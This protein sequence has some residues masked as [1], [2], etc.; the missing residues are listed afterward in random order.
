MYAILVPYRLYPPSSPIASGAREKPRIQQEVTPESMAARGGAVRIEIAF[1]TPVNPCEACD[2]RTGRLVVQETMP[3]ALEDGMSLNDWNQ[4]R[5]AMQRLLD[6][7]A[8]L[9]RHQL[10]GSFVLMAFFILIFF[11]AAAS[12]GMIWSGRFIVIWLLLPSAM[13]GMFASN[14]YFERQIAD[15]VHKMRVLCNETSQRHPG[16]IFLVRTGMFGNFH[17]V[18]ASR[19]GQRIAFHIQAQ[20]NTGT[21][22]QHD[23]PVVAGAPLVGNAVVGTA[24]QAGL[25]PTVEAVAVPY[26]SGSSRPV[27]LTQQLTELADLR[28][29]GLLSEHEFEQAKAQ[30]LGT[31][32]TRPP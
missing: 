8:R 27:S 7:L 31:S 14:A 10:A 5:A 32:T 15:C 26:H 1:N 24:V 23:T 21:G 16:V 9:K 6:P 22:T 30:I 13:I 19:Y 18:G 2:D 17:R 3:S 12:R 29:R 4:W 25:V 11:F 20:T 28:S